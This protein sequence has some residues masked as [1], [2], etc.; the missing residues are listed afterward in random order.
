MHCLR[1]ELKQMQTQSSGGTIVNAA[2]TA[3][4][5]GLFG[6]AAYTASKHAVIGLTKTCARDYAKK[7]IRVNAIA[8]GVTETPMQTEIRKWVGEDGPQKAAQAVVPFGR[9]GAAEE[10]ARVIA[11]LLSDE[12]SFVSGSVY[13]ADGAWTSGY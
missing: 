3:G 1:E 10:V 5:I 6:H 9:L 8:P 12:A 13:T 4:Y 7:N 2:S 11:F